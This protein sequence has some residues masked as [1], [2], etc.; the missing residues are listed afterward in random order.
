MKE[1]Y[2]KRCKTCDKVFRTDSKRAT[3]CE[4][5]KSF[6]KFKASMAA[7]ERQRLKRLRQNQNQDLMLYARAID[8]Y[9]QIHKTNYSYGRFGWYLT[10]G[11]IDN[12]EFGKILGECG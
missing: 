3:V 7:K 9:N 5:C 8:R 10:C 2:I 4:E 1:L 6:S 11:R 12:K